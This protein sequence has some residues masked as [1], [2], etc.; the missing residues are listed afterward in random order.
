MT[1]IYHKKKE[2]QWQT[3]SFIPNENMPIMTMQKK[4]ANVWYTGGV[5]AQSEPTLASQEM[6]R[7][8]KLE[9]ER[10]VIVLLQNKL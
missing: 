5:R 3:W 9:G 7:K 6:K 4:N 8:R 2:K 10:A 1:N